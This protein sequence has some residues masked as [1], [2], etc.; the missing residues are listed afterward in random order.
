MV[1]GSVLNN[2]KSSPKGK[3]AHKRLRPSGVVLAHQYAHRSAGYGNT[4]SSSS[5]SVSHSYSTNSFGR[6]TLH[7][8]VLHATAIQARQITDHIDYQQ[9]HDSM[10]IDEH[11]RLAHIRA[12][13]YEDFFAQAADSEIDIHDILA[14]DTAADISHAGTEFAELLAIED[15][16]LGP[17]SR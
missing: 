16:L 4:G 5:R 7:Q 14:G 10:S 6:K 8:E 17:V 1:L 9:H 13:E 12:N 15:G 11:S 3:A 2:R